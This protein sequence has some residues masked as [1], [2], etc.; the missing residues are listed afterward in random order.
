MIVGKMLPEN[1]LRVRGRLFWD[2]Q[3][4]HMRLVH[5]APALAVIAYGT[6]G[7][8]I[9]PDVPPA[10]MPGNHMIDSQASLPFAAILAGEIVA[11]EDF[12]AR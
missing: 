9:R 3:K 10:H 7:H 8:E 12:A 6:R 4:P 2:V 5:F 11:P 1:V